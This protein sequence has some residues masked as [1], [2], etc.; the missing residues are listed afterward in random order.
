MITGLIIGIVVISGI[1][2]VFAMGQETGY[3]KAIK[4]LANKHLESLNNMKNGTIKH[5]KPDETRVHRERT[6]L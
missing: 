2:F 3:K 5:S 4:E 1:L 6:S